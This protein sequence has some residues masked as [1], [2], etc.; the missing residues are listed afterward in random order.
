M[1]QAAVAS[2]R[3]VVVVAALRSTF[4]ST[5]ALLREV[6]SNEKR[7]LDIQELFCPEAWALFEAGELARYHHSIAMTIAKSVL[8][9]D[10]VLLAQ[11]S[12]APAGELVRQLG[13]PVLSS[14]RSGVEAA[15]E[16]IRAR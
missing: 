12:M 13:V 4:E 11:A 6:A 15:M 9:T 5:T 16:R 1:A 3:R 10:V 8:P 2:G 7:P 14:P